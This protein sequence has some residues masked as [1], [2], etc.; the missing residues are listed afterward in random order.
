M[1]GLLEGSFLKPLHLDVP[2]PWGEPFHFTTALIFDVGVYLAVVGVLLAALNQLGL[3]EE[4]TAGTPGASPPR[5]PGDDERSQANCASDTSGATAA[6]LDTT[7]PGG[8][9]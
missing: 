2:L 9:R 6:D 3:E 8:A 7:G 4:G 5:R 1:L